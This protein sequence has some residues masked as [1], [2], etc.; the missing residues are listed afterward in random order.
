MRILMAGASGFLGTRL[1]ERL[2]GG[3]HE[4]TRLVRRAVRRAGEASWQPSQGQLDP[5]VVAGADVVINLAGANVGDH[6]WTNHYKGVLRSS[7]L[8]TTG[9]L[10][11]AIKQLPEGDRPRTMLQASGV[12]WYGDTGDHAA[13]EEDPAGDSFLADMCQVW[14]AATRPAED[15]GTRVVLLRTAPTIGAGGSLVKP[16]LLP[17]KLGAGAKIGNG[18]QWMAW[19]SLADW[20]AAAEFLIDREDLAGPVNMVSA[21]QC[22]NAEFTRAFG[23]AVRRPAVLTVPGA[24]LGVAF[25]EIAGEMLRSQRVV[26]AV[27]ER[28]GFV[29]SHPDVET[30]LRAAVGSEAGAPR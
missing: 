28:A 24:A 21:R 8:D 19:I 14:E 17:F 2:R 25:G 9:T 29:W 16:L 18:R 23:R 7:R 22:T 13:T 6:R 26:P 20:L 27:L 10:A 11:R 15:A 4:I 12:G 1:A 3:G 30:A 5:G